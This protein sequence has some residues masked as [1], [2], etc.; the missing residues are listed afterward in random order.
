[1]LAIDG[2]IPNA[3]RL[4]MK[5]SKALHRLIIGVT[6]LAAVLGW[7]LVP[8]VKEFMQHSL[9]AFASLDQQALERFI[10]SWGPQA[11]LVSFALM[12]LQAIIAPLPAFLITFAN[13][14]LFG[15]FWGGALSWV[16]A[17]AGAALCFFIARVLGRDAVEKLTGKSVL[18]SMDGFFNRYGKHTILV[19]RLLPF[20]PFDPVSYAAGLTSIR[21][22]HFM[23][24][25]GLGQ[26]PATIVYSWTGSLLTGGT[27]WLV[28][29]LSILFALAI[30]V[31]V[32]KA[33]YLEQQKRRSR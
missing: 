11:A 2:S 9:A 16:S 29:G 26:L 32:A 21:F 31:V 12:I 15:A 7:W 28:T 8:D 13:A 33:L 23:L 20:V 30:L 10:D 5:N 3:Y 25:T 17:M 4:T 22:R 14:S 27:F 6:L 1:M 24:A 19:C 18:Q